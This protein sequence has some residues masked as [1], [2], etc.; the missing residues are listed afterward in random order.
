MFD[1]CPE[2]EHPMS[3]HM[4]LVD[5]GGGHSEAL[6]CLVD[7]CDCMNYQKEEDYHSWETESPD[8]Y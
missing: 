3:H 7:N 4:G 5:M 6:G 1:D 8:D 2:C